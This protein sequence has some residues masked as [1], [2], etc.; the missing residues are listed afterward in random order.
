MKAE[1][2]LPVSGPCREE[3]WVLELGEVPALSCWYWAVDQKCWHFRR[4]PGKFRLEHTAVKYIF[5][6]LG[7]NER[8]HAGNTKSAARHMYPAAFRYNQWLKSHDGTHCVW[9]PSLSYIFESSDFATCNW[10]L[11]FSFPTQWLIWLWSC[12]FSWGSSGSCVTFI[13]LSF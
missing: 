10:A 9:I 13:H 2:T 6:S 8:V 11:W 5:F 3:M 1:E 12:M 7:V 4:R